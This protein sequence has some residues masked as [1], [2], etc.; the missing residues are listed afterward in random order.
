VEALASTE[1]EIEER[2]EP[3]G[4]VSSQ[5]EPSGRPPPS[6][7]SSRA[8]PIECSRGAC[9]AMGDSA[10]GMQLASFASTRAL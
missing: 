6:R 5:T 4:P 10:A 1:G 9:W 8:L 3:S 2:T 7:L